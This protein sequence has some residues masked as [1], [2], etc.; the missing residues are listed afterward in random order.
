MA[1]WIVAVSALVTCLGCNAALNVVVKPPV[2]NQCE[3]TGLKG[4]DE[5]TEAVL[6]YIDGKKDE[7]RTKLREGVAKNSNTRVRRYAAGL[8]MITSLP[9]IA[10]YA[11]PINEVCDLLADE[12]GG[13]LSEDEVKAAA[14]AP[15]TAAGKKDEDQ[16]VNTSKDHGLRSA[17]VVPSAMA[18]AFS[19]Q[20]FSALESDGRKALCVRVSTGP[21]II[22]DIHV[23]AGCSNEVFI[24]AGKISRPRWF[25]IGSPSGTA[26]HGAKLVVKSDEPLIVGVRVAGPEDDIKKAAIC[27]VTWAAAEP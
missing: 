25:V 19:C 12:T 4:C 1:K 6:L 15:T 9:G 27:S 16:S 5:M 22:S 7:A 24:L 3:G 26:M 10:D 11:G 8:R 2:V 14:S 21:L 23:G 13:P 17:T 20:P 18:N